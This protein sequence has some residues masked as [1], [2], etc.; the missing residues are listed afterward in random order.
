MPVLD[1]DKISYF[2]DKR[3]LKTQLGQGSQTEGTVKTNKT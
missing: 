1:E 2:V 3:I